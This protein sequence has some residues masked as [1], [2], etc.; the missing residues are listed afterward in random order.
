MGKGSAT[1]FA[2]LIVV[3]VL[4]FAYLY[5][6]P[7]TPISEYTSVYVRITDPP[8]IPKGASS[9]NITYSG[10]GLQVR[11]SSGTSWINSGESGSINL[12]ALQNQT[13]TLSSIALPQGTTPIALE[14]NITSGSITINGSEYPMDIVSKRINST[15]A[16]LSSSPGS[17]SFSAILSMASSV[18]P[19]FA[20]NSTSFFFQAFPTSV[21]LSGSPSVS[22]IGSISKLNSSEAVAI[23]NNTPKIRIL[24]SSLSSEGNV[25]SISTTIED[26]SSIPL[27]LEM[28][29]ISG[30]ESVKIEVVKPAIQ[31]EPSFG[32]ITDSLLINETFNAINSALG[33]LINNQTSNLTGLAVSK[34][35]SG[36]L[37]KIPGYAASTASKIAS[38]L[39]ISGPEINQISSNL[40]STQSNSFINGIFSNLTDSANSIYINGSNAASVTSTLIKG[41]SSGKINSSNIANIKNLIANAKAEATANFPKKIEARQSQFN[42]LSFIAAKNSSLIPTISAS[43]IT[44]AEYGYL[45]EP[46]R[47]V[48]LVYSGRISAG[49]G[50]LGI[51][52]INGNPYK[53]SVIGT[54]GAY[55]STEIK[56]G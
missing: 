33:Y 27:V 16:N 48:T 49:N 31:A 15:I 24:S 4:A 20:G 40:N 39:N 52:L 22:G 13:E 14:M 41:I 32:H 44:G 19:S 26:N 29:A 12:L 5:L 56:A 55:A 51:S 6:N 28:L 11:N 3:V 45:L 34:L 38:Q 9:I 43:S 36:N 17:K 2:A 53:I 46:G 54:D 7:G 37:T 42:Y 21:L 1:A 10:I 50:I 8:I 18:S 30:N 25:S 35:A 23:V 47:S